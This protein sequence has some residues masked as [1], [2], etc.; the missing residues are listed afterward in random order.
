MSLYKGVGRKRT[1]GKRDVP[2]EK[3]VVG[4]MGSSG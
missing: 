4:E 3:E 2:E 1:G